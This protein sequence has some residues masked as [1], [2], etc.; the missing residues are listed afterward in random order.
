M[1]KV[2]DT[3]RHWNL[4]TEILVAMQRQFFGAWSV[5]SPLPDEPVIYAMNHQIGIDLGFLLWPISFS[6]G[7]PA[8]VVI[9]GTAFDGQHGKLFDALVSHPS[10]ANEDRRL[11]VRLIG[12]DARAPRLA[13]DAM[14]SLLERESVI[15]SVEGKAQSCDEQPVARGSSLLPNLSLRTGR[16]IV[17]VRFSGGLPK[18]PSHFRA[19]PHDYGPMNAVSG[20]P[21]SAA[22]LRDLPP[23]QRVRRVIDG[24]NTLVGQGPQDKNRA[25]SQG[26]SFAEC[27]AERQIRTGSSAVKCAIV[28]L[29]MRGPVLSREA[30]DFLKLFQPE[31]TALPESLDTEWGRRFTY[32]LTDGLNLPEGP[33]KYDFL[34]G[35]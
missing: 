25:Q 20:E 13:V 16:P 10:H 24:V 18:V 6:T 26:P 27:V 9:S 29:L 19:L 21:I 5:L 2:A 35:R 28:E 33:E 15:V 14:R 34:S 32:W 4:S 22:E 30:R 7:V 1:G 8:S 23:R 17:P 11:Q 12:F 31:V 3:V